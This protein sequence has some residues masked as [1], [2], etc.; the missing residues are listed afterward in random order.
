MCI[1]TYG[2]LGAGTIEHWN[3]M[4]YID[5]FDFVSYR[6]TLFVFVSG[7]LTIPDKKPPKRT[8]T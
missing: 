1:V 4:D 8:I 5:Y 3:V 6:I 7:T 2:F